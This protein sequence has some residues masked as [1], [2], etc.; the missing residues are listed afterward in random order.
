M[1]TIKGYK[2]KVLLT[3]VLVGWGLKTLANL[4]PHL[5]QLYTSNKCKKKK[6]IYIY[7]SYLV[8][9]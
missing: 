6:Y 9:L 4:V 1:K 8:C 3:G 2:I 7:V 5:S